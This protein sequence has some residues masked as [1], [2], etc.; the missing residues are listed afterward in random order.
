[1]KLRFFAIAAL[2]FVSTFAQAQSKPEEMIRLRQGGM[3]LLTRNLAALSAMA[4]GDVPYNKDVAV[5]K[6]DFVNALVAEVFASGFGPGSDKGWQTRAKPAIWTEGDNFKAAQEKLL[7]VLKKV[8]AGAGD[9][10]ALKTAM[11]DVSVA[12]KGCHDNYR[13]SSYH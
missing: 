1:M 13:D 12:C 8:Q 3:Q 2:A 4:K 6:A 7:G 5:Q 9:Q 11:G 10:A